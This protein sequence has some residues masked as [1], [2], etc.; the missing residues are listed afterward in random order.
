MAA[1][2]ASLLWH[3]DGEQL[4]NPFRKHEGSGQVHWG[5]LV[6]SFVA[7]LIVAA[8]AAL[9]LAECAL[10]VGGR[11]VETGRWHP[12]IGQNF[13]VLVVPIVLVVMMLGSTVLTGLLTQIE[14]EEEREWWA[15]A[16]G[17]LF[18]CLLCWLALN[19]VAFFAKDWLHFM[20]ASILGA[21]GLGAGYIGRAAYDFREVPEQA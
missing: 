12:V 5:R 13:V 7:P 3:N 16:G 10:R 9:L 11:L 17:L 4:P 21:A 19:S 20:S 1:V 15:R 2:R 18:S 8:L 14:R 6:W